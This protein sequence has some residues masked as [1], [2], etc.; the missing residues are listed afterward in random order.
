MRGEEPAEALGMPL[1]IAETAYGAVVGVR[2]RLYDSGVLNSRKAG[3]TELLVKKLLPR[4]VGILSRGYGAGNTSA[5]QIVSDGETLAAPPPFSADEPYM[6]ASRLSGVPVVCAP[7]RIDGAMEMCNRF[8]VEAIVLDDGYQHRAI[9]R[10]FDILI[11]SAHNP[12]GSGKLL[13]NGILREPLE[14]VKRAGLIVIT[15]GG[16]IAENDIIELKIRIGK[17][18]PSAPVVRAVGDIRG[19]TN[20]EGLM[21]GVAGKKLFAFCGIASPE[22]FVSSLKKAG[23]EVVE[24]VFFADHYQYDREDVNEI[25]RRISRCGAEAAVTTEKDF[26]RL[27][28]HVDNFGGKLLKASYE[29]KI[30]EGE[31][32]LDQKLSALF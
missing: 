6:M 25:L 7:K 16:D 24:T 31:D 1:S 8:G 21:S 19:F 30:T 17:L 22:R 11:V 27:I 28:R 18:N 10:D 20:S 14:Q 2:N 32:A 3:C 15:E 29:L 9:H 26:V 12:F 13:P 5:V 4:K 23:A